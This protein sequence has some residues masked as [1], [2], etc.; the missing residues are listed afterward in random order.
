MCMLGQGLNAEK[1]L[2]TA[3]ALTVQVII[4]LAAFLTA[5]YK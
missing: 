2:R 4:Y 1:S 5:K 3:Y